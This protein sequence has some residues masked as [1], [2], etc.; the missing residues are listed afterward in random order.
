MGRA[1]RRFIVGVRQLSGLIQWPAM[2]RVSRR[3]TARQCL[4]AGP[5][6]GAGVVAA[7]SG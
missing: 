3:R 4:G 6:Q 5:I 1:L 2:E 7:R